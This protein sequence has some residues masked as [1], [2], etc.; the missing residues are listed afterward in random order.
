M[1]PTRP[2]ASRRWSRASS[3]AS[4][5]VKASPLVN[6]IPATDAAVMIEPPVPALRLALGQF[7]EADAEHAGG[8]LEQA[9][10]AAVAVLAQVGGDAAR[11]AC[12]VGRPRRSNLDRSAGGKHSSASRP[13]IVAGERLAVD[14]RRQDAA[15]AVQPLEAGDLLVDPARLGRVGRAKHDQEARPGDRLLDLLAEVARRRPVPAGRGRSG[16]SRLGTGPLVGQLADQPRRDTKFLKLSRAASRRPR[17]SW[18]L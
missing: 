14:D 15:F 12:V 9:H 17:S 16:A 6:S 8:D 4:I 10:P 5:A 3:R 2:S 7:V 18:W 1:K 13:G 11:R